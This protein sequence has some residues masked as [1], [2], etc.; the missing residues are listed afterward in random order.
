MIHIRT[1]NNEIN[2]DREFGCGIGPEL[3]KGDIYFFASEAS[4]V[5][6]SDCPGCNPGGPKKMGMPISQLSGRPGHPGYGKFVDIAR[7][8]GYD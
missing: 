6:K 1:D 7:S 3:P 5:Y 8:W 4:A 2:S